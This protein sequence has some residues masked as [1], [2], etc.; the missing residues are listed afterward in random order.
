MDYNSTL[1][2]VTFTAG[3]IS[4]VANVPVIMDNIVEG[5]EIFDLSL[6]IPSSLQGQVIPG[7]ITKAIGSIIDNTSKK[8]CSI[9]I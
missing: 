1:V 4:A 6:D 3:S 5:P 2:N 9:Y 8:I 7:T